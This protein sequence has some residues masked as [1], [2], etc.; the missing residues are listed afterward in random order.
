MGPFAGGAKFLTLAF[1]GLKSKPKYLD[2]LLDD[3][4]G[5]AACRLSREGAAG[6]E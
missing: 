4:V 3:D 6:A 1:H 2:F 5:G